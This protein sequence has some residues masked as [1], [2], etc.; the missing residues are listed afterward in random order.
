M[1]LRSDLTLYLQSL[2]F[3]EVY[4]SQTKGIYLTKLQYHVF[5]LKIVR[6][7]LLG[8]SQSPSICKEQGLYREM[9]QCKDIYRRIVEILHL[10]H[11][12][13]VNCCLKVHIRVFHSLYWIRH[14]TPKPVIISSIRSSPTRGFFFTVVKS[15]DANN[16]ISANFV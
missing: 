3:L 2:H 8:Q 5:F 9:P 7:V 4:C 13:K 15:F 10:N 12:F 1:V 14:W 16:G 11:I 6:P